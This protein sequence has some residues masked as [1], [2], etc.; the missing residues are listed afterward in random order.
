MFRQTSD[1]LPVSYRPEGADRFEVV[2]D[3][4]TTCSDFEAGRLVPVS[5]CP[6][7]AVKC[8]E[9]YAFL[10]DGSEPDWLWQRGADAASAVLV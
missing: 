10:A 4:C 3:V 8:A 2:A 1:H 9:Y 6:D 7:A 5:F